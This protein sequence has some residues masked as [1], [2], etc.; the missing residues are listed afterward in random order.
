MPKA[1]EPAPDITFE[2]PTAE[3]E[4]LERMLL[5]Q[6]VAKPFE[7]P[8]EDQRVAFR[9]LQAVKDLRDTGENKIKDIRNLATDLGYGDVKG[10]KR[11]DLVDWL[12]NYEADRWTDYLPEVPTGFWI[13]SPE[14]VNYSTPGDPTGKDNNR[15][16]V[17]SW[18]DEDAPRAMSPALNKGAI[19]TFN[20]ISKAFNG[21]VYKSNKVGGKGWFFQNTADAQRFVDHVRQWEQYYKDITPAWIREE[22]A[23]YM[24]NDLPEEYGAGPATRKNGNLETVDPPIRDAVEMALA[25]MPLEEATRVRDE[26]QK[27]VSTP[28][29]SGAIRSLAIREMFDRALAGKDITDIAESEVW[30]KDKLS[31][32]KMVKAFQ[33]GKDA[34]DIFARS[35]NFVGSNRKAEHDV[36]ASFKNCAPSPDCAKFC[37]SLGVNSR[38]VELLKAEFTEYMAENNPQLV[39]DQIYN[40]FRY[41]AAAASGLALRLNDKGDL[42]DAEVTV[43]NLSLIHISEPTRLQ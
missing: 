8:T 24:V 35:Y 37:Y 42:S 6:E 36:S 2:E 4:Q 9:R 26:L 34:V 23:E 17:E 15:V 31:R 20:Q 19:D 25:K 3:R 41:T 32:Y 10:V 7:R 16:I 33:H 39:A 14:M 38:P 28:W 13:Q 11:A 1:V 40:D 30:G 21:S 22:G 12:E 29:A 5:Q 43:I 18:T 27:N